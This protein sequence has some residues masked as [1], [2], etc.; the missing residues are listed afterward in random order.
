[1]AETPAEAIAHD[2]VCPICHLLLFDPVRTRCNHILCAS[3]MAQWADT[4]ALSNIIPSRLDLNLSDFSPDYVA[5]IHAEA[6]CPMC[7]TL[8]T[9]SPDTTLKTA[10]AQRYPLTY[11][12]RR[13]EELALRAAVAGSG[14][15]TEGMVI[16]IG[17]KHRIDRAAENRNTHDWTWFLRCSRP[18]LIEEVRV[19]L[20]DSFRPPQLTL[21]APPFEVHRWGWGSFTVKANVVLKEPYSWI[22]DGNSAATRNPVITL[23]WTLSFEGRGNQ[24]RV[25]AKVRKIL[26]DP[27]DDGRASPV[28]WPHMEADHV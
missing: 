17:N 7:R 23:D 22:T 24:G 11:E 14:H 15:G 13:V 1:M 2:D 3:C 25:R 12:E 10:L 16:L 4:T 27:H 6:N 5:A 28:A 9:A 8:T 26:E 19:S 21:R 18:D 20:H